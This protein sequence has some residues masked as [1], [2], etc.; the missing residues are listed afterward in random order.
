[1]SDFMDFSSE[2]IQIFAFMIDQS[3]SM[4]DDKEN[5]IEGVQTYQKKLNNILEANSIA[6]SISKFESQI[7]LGEFQHIR[8]MRFRYE[9]CGRTA[10]Y[11]AIVKGANH[12]MQYMETVV[13]KHGCI[14][15]A[16][17]ILFS[18]GRDN[19]SDYFASAARDS[20]RKL[21]YVGIDTIFVPF[22]TAIHSSFGEDL[23]FKITREVKNS[24]ELVYFLGE[25]LSNAS[26]RQSQSRKSLGEAFFSQAKSSKNY[27]E[28]TRQVLEEDDWMDFI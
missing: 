11:D 16:T 3:G 6:V 12:L 5:V 24:E 1:M 17:F 25:E 20:I 18:D 27:S 23:D 28:R 9:P 4:E 22:G 26:I 15:K 2:N 19:M 10:L 13:K 8:D 14:P 21:N 7:M